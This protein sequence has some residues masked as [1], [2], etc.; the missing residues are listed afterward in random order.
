[1]FSGSWPE[2]PVRAT[3]HAHWFGGY[4]P[5]SQ[6]P[7]PAP[8]ISGCAGSSSSSPPRSVLAACGRVTERESA[9]TTGSAPTTGAPTTGAAT[10]ETTQPRRARS[11]G[12]RVPT[13]SA[14]RVRDADR[15]DRLR[16]VG[17]NDRPRVSCACL[18]ARSPSASA[19]ML[20]NPGGPGVPGTEL[21]V[22]GDVDLAARTSVTGSTSSAWDPRGTGGSAPVDCVG[23]PRPLLRRARSVA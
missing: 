8:T 10:T 5:R 12:R 21:V 19:R 15:P 18:R 9:A 1:M 4:G 23:R 17:Q 14:H 6:A 2:H 11:A 13:W 20:V 22:G 7:Q 3:H 16:C